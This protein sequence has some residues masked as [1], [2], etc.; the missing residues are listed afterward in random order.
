M[1]SANYS[2][3]FI[4]ET[5]TLVNV[6]SSNHERRR[7]RTRKALARKGKQ[8]ARRRRYAARRRRI[9]Y[10]GSPS[11]IYQNDVGHPLDDMDDI[12]TIL[13]QVSKNL[14]HPRAVVKVT[15][16]YNQCY[17]MQTIDDLEDLL[18]NDSVIKVE[19]VDIN[20][21]PADVAPNI[22]ILIYR[23]GNEAPFDPA[24]IKKRINYIWSKV[25]TAGIKVTAMFPVTTA[26][27]DP[28]VSH[29]YD[30]RNRDMLTRRIEQPDPHGFMEKVAAWP[31]IRHAYDEQ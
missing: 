26:F 20:H 7:G 30:V 16:R 17:Y 18:T 4:Q 5:N 23:R 8:T 14:E 9:Q 11:I 3:A 29:V 25:P 27:P 10:G 31:T 22:E 21:L 2:I 13:R 1:A 6:M 19:I 15:T 12:V 24:Y 28:T